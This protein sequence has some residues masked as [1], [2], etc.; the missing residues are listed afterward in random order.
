MAFQVFVSY[1]AA[2]SEIAL[3][4][5]FVADTWIVACRDARLGRAP[6]CTRN[7]RYSASDMRKSRVR[8]ANITRCNI[9]CCGAYIRYATV[10]YKPPTVTG[11][12]SEFNGER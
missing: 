9:A 5:V 8:G 12:V 11:S 3:G 10:A 4:G 6:F 2:V 1:P 7:M